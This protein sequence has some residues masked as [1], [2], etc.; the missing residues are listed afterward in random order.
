MDEIIIKAICAGVGISLITGLLGCFVVWKKMS[1]FGDS[2]AHCS[3]LGIALG[4]V[5]SINA[6]ISILIVA[7]IFAILLTYLQ[8]KGGLSTDTL[9]GIFSHGGLAA[10]MIL[11]SFVS[12]QE[13]FDL[14]E[15]LFG[16]ILKVNMMEIYY[17]YIV[18]AII[19]GFMHFYWK[20]LIILTINTDLAEAQGI[21][22]FKY[23]LI[24]VFLMMLTVV[25]SIKIVGLL[26]VTSMFII[27]SA[28]ARSISN[29]PSS[30]AI[31]SILIA[32]ISVISGILASYYLHSPSGPS[33]VIS[34]IGIFIIIAIFSKI[35]NHRY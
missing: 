10:G 6:N 4:L 32:I 18:C 23:Q 14:H 7:T 33:I 27:P 1:Y 30:M 26:L 9:L 16:D 2:I 11:I 17:I 13:H 34:A 21:K 12:N 28:T 35:H 8:H 25:V 20:K 15:F 3:L 5:F 24:L 31:L 22:K 29:S 19:F